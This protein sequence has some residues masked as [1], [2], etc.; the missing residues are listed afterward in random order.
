MSA[1]AVQL[2]NGIDTDA[3][4]GVIREVAQDSSKGQTHWQVTTEWKGGT[5]SDTQVD[6]CNIGGQTV[7]KK[8]NISVDEP[9]ELGGTNQFANPQEILMAGLNSCMAVGYVVGCAMHGIVLESLRIETEGDIDLRGFLGLDPN[10]VPGYEELRYQV[11]I[12]GQGTPEQFQQVHE[13]VM[14][15]SPNRFNL[16]TAI[17]LKAKLVVEQGR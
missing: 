12:K 10:V 11:F 15:S 14:K 17:P 5:R 1:T 6:Q 16:A 7:H 13:T 4:R 9:L 8:F 3:L 2:I